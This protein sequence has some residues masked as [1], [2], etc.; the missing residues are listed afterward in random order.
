MLAVLGA[1]AFSFIPDGPLG[2]AVSSTHDFICFYSVP[3][4]RL[5]SNRKPAKRNIF[6]FPLVSGS[7]SIVSAVYRKLLNNSHQSGVLPEQERQLFIST[8]HQWK[9]GT[10]IARNEAGLHGE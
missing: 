3:S 9:A 6:L 2:W 5:F 8:H 7:A 4:P 1:R 10:K